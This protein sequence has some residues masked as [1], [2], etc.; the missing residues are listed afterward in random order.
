MLPLIWILITSWDQPSIPPSVYSISS[1]S[2]TL[3]NLTHLPP[4]F[5][6][7]IAVVS[8]GSHLHPRLVDVVSKGSK[9]KQSYQRRLFDIVQDLVADP[10]FL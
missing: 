5:S 7:H 1:H 10:I 6:L 8:S 9:T 2:L 4:K 3:T